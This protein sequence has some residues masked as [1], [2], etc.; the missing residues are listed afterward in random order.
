MRVQALFLNLFMGARRRSP[1]VL[2]EAKL[3]LLDIRLASNR[4]SLSHLRFSFKRIWSSSSAPLIAGVLLTI[5][6]VVSYGLSKLP[7]NYS[8]GIS[9]V[10]EGSIQNSLWLVI[11]SL[12]AVSLPIF[13]VVVQYSSS[14]KN[15]IIALPVTEVLRRE[16]KVDAALIYAAVSIVH[17]GADTV[18]IRCKP[19]LIFDFIVTLVV[20]VVMIGN[21][22]FRLFQLISSRFKLNELGYRLLQDKLETAIDNTW[23][24][25]EANRVVIAELDHIGVRFSPLDFPFRPPEWTQ[26]GPPSEFTVRDI[27][28]D[29]LIVVAGTLTGLNQMGVAVTTVRNELETTPQLIL[30]RLC[31]STIGPTLPMFAYQHG[32]FGE[33][34]PEAIWGLI[35]PCLVLR[36]V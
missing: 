24:I 8:Y 4:N 26:I 20:L 18:W 17:S 11:A 22:Y 19:V 6:Q 1:L 28:I 15:G 5:L 7:S 14:D 2:K 3:R 29:A 35:E 31:E 25:A 36:K 34:A 33:Q 13:V 27:D 23:V 16:S 9:N 30:L 21:S 10:N 12:V 32:N